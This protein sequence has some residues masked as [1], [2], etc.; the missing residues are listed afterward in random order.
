MRT[1]AVLS[2]YHAV[3]SVVNSQ[4]KLLE[5]FK[6]FDICTMGAPVQIYAI[7]TKPFTGRQGR[8]NTSSLPASHAPLLVVDHRMLHFGILAA[9]ELVMI[10]RI[11]GSLRTK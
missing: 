5:D 1:M 9:E 10:I 4:L 3:G 6:I 11:T 8:A 7:Q 2:S